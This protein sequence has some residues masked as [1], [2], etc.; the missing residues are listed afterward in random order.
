MPA[1]ADIQN[2]E[3]VFVDELDLE[4]TSH[5]V[6]GL[7]E[8]GVVGTAAAVANATIT[9]P[10]SMFAVCPSNRQ[11]TRDGGLGITVSLKLLADKVFVIT[12]ASAGIGPIRA[13]L[14]AGWGDQARTRRAQRW[15][16]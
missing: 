11:A 6:E 7:G 8:I 3:V 1:N 15:P 9:R 12:G 10:V 5:G 2:T 14:A 4:V 16:L 13:K